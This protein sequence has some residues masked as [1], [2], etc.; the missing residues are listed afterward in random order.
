MVVNLLNQE[1]D[2]S[3]SAAVFVLEKHQ[4]N[5]QGVLGTFRASSNRYLKLLF[6]LCHYN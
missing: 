5:G 6:D 2:E 4:D 1:N 3:D